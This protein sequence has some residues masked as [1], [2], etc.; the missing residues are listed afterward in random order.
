MDMTKFEGVDDPGFVA[1]AGELRRWSRE[2][3]SSSPSGAHS[4]T[5]AQQEQPA[6][7]GGPWCT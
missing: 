7:K 6:P 1:V 2:L 5:L 4:E 3:C